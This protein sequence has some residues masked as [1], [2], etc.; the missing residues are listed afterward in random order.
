M[1]NNYEILD[2]IVKAKDIDVDISNSL[3]KNLSSTDTRNIYMFLFIL[4]IFFIILLW[5]N[6]ITILI[7]MTILYFVLAILII[8]MIS[9]EVK[10]NLKIHNKKIYV[11][12]DLRHHYINYS[13]LVNFEIKK[14][15]KTIIKHSIHGRVQIDAL[16]ISYF[17]KGKIYK[18][19]LEIKDCI[20]PEIKDICNA[21]ITKKQLANAPDSFDDYFYT[22]K[23]NINEKLKSIERYN[24]KTKIYI[25][26]LIIMLIALLI[27]ILLSMLH[28]IV[29][30]SS[31]TFK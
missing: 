1:T 22:C 26:Y 31:Y 18:V 15:T 25:Q 16:V 17:K 23:E 30:L 19:T 20:K 10:W 5:N 9:F 11:N 2:Y 6:T 24:A 29:T 28:I 14:V 21:F 8:K 7:L 12:Y 27:L 3:K 4:Y 13:D